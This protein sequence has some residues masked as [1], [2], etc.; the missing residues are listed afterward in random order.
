MGRKPLEE[1]RRHFSEKEIIVNGG[2]K[3]QTTCKYCGWKQIQK[4]IN[5]S[6][7]KDHLIDTCKHFAADIKKLIIDLVGKSSKK[8]IDKQVCAVLDIDIESA[9]HIDNPMAVAQT[10]SSNP[11]SS[12]SGD[13]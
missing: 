9:E 8:V 2:K 12:G 1:A 11:S 13:C 4:G 3:I 6:R 5:A 7:M 10:A